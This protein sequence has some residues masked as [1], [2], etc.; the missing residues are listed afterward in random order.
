MPED[1]SIEAVLRREQLKNLCICEVDVYGHIY[2]TGCGWV[3]SGVSDYDDH[4]YC[5]KCGNAI[6]VQA[7]SAST[8]SEDGVE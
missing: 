3:V 2:R 1:R 4:I 5:P 7:D 8:G 6:A